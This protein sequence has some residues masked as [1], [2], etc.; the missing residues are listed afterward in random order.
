MLL[1]GAVTISSLAKCLRISFL[2]FRRC[3][4]FAWIEEKTLYFYAVTAHVSSA[5]IEC[6]SVRCVANPW[7]GGFCYFSDLPL[8]AIAEAPFW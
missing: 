8:S 1:K 4:Q 6:R 7:R 3:V 5:E 2:G